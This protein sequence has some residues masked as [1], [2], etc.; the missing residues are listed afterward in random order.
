MPVDPLPGALAPVG[1]YGLTTEEFDALAGGG[2]TAASLARIWDGERSHRL[3]LLDLFLDLMQEL[4]RACG[5]LPAARTAWDLLLRA[6][7][8]DRAVVEGMLLAPETGLWVTAVL[9][10]LGGGP[11]GEVPLWV[12]A[13]HFHAL[14]AASAVRAGL[15]FE[16]AVPVRHGALWLPGLGR[17]VAAAPKPWST[18][19]VSCV[20][21][22]LTLRIGRRS[23][24][25]AAPWDEPAPGWEP[26]RTVSLPLDGARTPVLLDDLGCH[27]I[28][29]S[30][31]AAPPEPLDD[32]EAGAWAALLHEAAALLAETDP[33]AA[34]DIAVLLRSVEPLPAPGTERPVSATSGDGVGRL[35]SSRPPDAVQLAAVLAHEI[36]HSKLGALMHLYPLYEAGDTS[37]CYAP[38]RDDPRPLRGLLQGVYAFTGVARFWR[39]R[40]LSSRATG[41]DSRAAHFEY[42]LWRRQLLRVLPEM[43]RH[44]GL[45]HLGRRTVDRLSETVAGWGQPQRG[46][47]VDVMAGEAADHHAMSWRLH[48]LAPDATS[49]KSLVGVWP[50]PPARVPPTPPELRPDPEVP[51]LDTLTTLYRTRL[52]DPRGIEE[53]AGAF[54]GTSALT[55]R[56]GGVRALHVRGDT[57]GAVAL[58]A[59]ALRAGEAA[60]PSLWADLLTALGA[61]GDGPAGR[62]ARGRP[63]LARVVYEEIRKADGAAPDPVSFVAWLDDCEQGG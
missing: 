10:R 16:L 42:A 48:H 34:T 21:G 12:E 54:A 58:A 44:P 28:G 52:S 53:F 25:V 62:V 50:R 13:G 61:R 46:G 17:A 36:Q 31:A 29:A 2:G 22:E 27:R 18:A 11:G 55:A 43:G 14:A 37:L 33:Q 59:T 41:E 30:Q 56:T 38:W 23:R 63:E 57:A 40:A 51:R 45:T 1:R 5:P 32:A 9:R 6:N 3:L 35:A 20:E 19:L 49:V 39:G 24:R 7:D 47:P 26:A 4:P 15:D 8:R 60:E